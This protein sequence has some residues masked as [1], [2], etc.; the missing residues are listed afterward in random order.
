MAHF[1]KPRVKP[2]HIRIRKRDG[3]RN[4]FPINYWI[5]TF[6]QQTLAVH[7]KRKRVVAEQKPIPATEHSQRPD[8]LAAL[9][10]EHK[11]R[12]P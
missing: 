6:H 3:L 9:L 10:D 8:L 1:N 12:I 11:V 2:N 7:H 5:K 4:T